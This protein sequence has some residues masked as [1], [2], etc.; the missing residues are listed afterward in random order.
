LKSKKKLFNLTICLLVLTCLVSCSDQQAAPWELS[1]FEFDWKLDWPI[2]IVG[3]IEVD[4]TLFEPLEDL[5]YYNFLAVCHTTH[6]REAIERLESLEIE[7]SVLHVG[8]GLNSG[9]TL[10]GGSRTIEECVETRCS[11]GNLCDSNSGY[12]YPENATPCSRVC[13]RIAECYEQVDQC[14]SKCE[15]MLRGPCS[16]GV[17]PLSEYGV[18]EYVRGLEMLTCEEM[19]EWDGL[20]LFPSMYHQHPSTILPAGD[21]SKFQQAA[22]TQRSAFISFASTAEVGE[23]IQVCRE[24]RECAE[25]IQCLKQEGLI[26]EDI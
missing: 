21:C 12:C 26:D 19:I 22:I 5:C 20:R 9:S 23:R 1:E 18:S 7:Y 15:L 3:D 24:F 17:C 16:G 4:M 8:G 11:E 25:Q 6:W 13:L 14:E 2:A 10:P